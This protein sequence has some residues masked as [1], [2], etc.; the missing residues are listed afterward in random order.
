LHEVVGRPFWQTPWFAGTPGA[1][2]AMRAAVTAAVAGRTVRQ[3]VELELPIGRRRF[4]F[5]SRP[6]F[7]T[8]G[9]LAGLVPEAVDI[10]DAR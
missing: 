10:T 9:E 6:V 5:T 2:D 4:D 7:S 3:D 1:S 8:R